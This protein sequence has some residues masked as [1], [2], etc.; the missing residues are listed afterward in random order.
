[1]AITKTPIEVGLAVVEDRGTIPI[2]YDP[3]SHD[4]FFSFA[5]QVIEGK[6]YQQVHDQATK[7]LVE[8]VSPVPTW[9]RVTVVVAHLEPSVPDEYFTRQT[10]GW[11]FAALYE[12]EVA[13]RGA[14]WYIRPY[15]RSERN[16]PATALDT[17]AEQLP[18]TVHQGAG[19]VHY[20]FAHDRDTHNELSRH[21]SLFR[22]LGEYVEKAVRALHDGRVARD[23]MQINWRE[24]STIAEDVRQLL[25]KLY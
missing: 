20:I 6:D 23:E 11:S 17:T 4:H 14:S 3:V 7:M 24:L 19:F 15:G 18:L 25:V 8:L 10:M 16:S 2:M 1:M 12:A 9:E 22:G 5:M 13:K 21:F